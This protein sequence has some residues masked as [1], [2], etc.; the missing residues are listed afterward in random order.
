MGVIQ[1]FRS[2]KGLYSLIQAQHDIASSSST[3]DESL[4]QL[5]AGGQL[6]SIKTSPSQRSLPTNIK[7]KDLFDS[8][9]WSDPT[10]ASVFYRFIS[11]LREKIRQDVK[12]TTS[13]H[14]FIR[15]LRDRRKLVRCYTQN[16][17]GLET[18]ENLATDL[19]LGKGNRQR[20]TKKSMEQ[21]LNSCYTGP[22][23]DFD[24]GCEVVQL[25]GEL[26]NLRCSLC[27]KT[28]PWDALHP[29][30]KKSL[31]AGTPPFCQSC[32]ATDQDRQDRGKRGTKIGTLRPNIVL[33]GEDHPSADVLGSIATH[34][35]TLSPDLLLILGTSLH[36]HG[37]R[38]LVREFAKSVH[39]RPGGRGKVVF[40][41][42]SR[43]TESIWKDAIDIW[44]DMDC[45][46]WVRAMRKHRPDLF[47][48][49]EELKMPTKKVIN[50]SPSKNPVASSKDNEREKENFI[51]DASIAV[52][53]SKA[54]KPRVVVP[55][56]PRKKKPLQER[57]VEGTSQAGVGDT[58]N[59]AVT[60][61]VSSPPVCPD[62]LPTPLPSSTD[63]SAKKRRKMLT[64]TY[65]EMAQTPTKRRRKMLVSI[66][67]D[68]G[69]GA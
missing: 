32:L 48:V 38:R 8:R 60:Q 52:L 1:D 6:T 20:F 29:Q 31:L 40:V 19:G 69:A 21:P 24:P 34:D 54:N 67:S 30:H 12:H 15:T 66:W 10:S 53:P 58:F 39:A 27:Q 37:L 26:E 55:L 68:V 46:A 42:F 44:V 57:E 28:F 43:P 13:T 3:S 17:D 65:N 22:G 56:T 50:R 7:G 5:S 47:Q 64:E 11:S 23:R 4:S 41:N 59:L 2:E 16:I 14:R 63:G 49:Q 35:L 9:L 33:Y 18:R 25:H 51:I 62:H 61:D 45:D 36:V